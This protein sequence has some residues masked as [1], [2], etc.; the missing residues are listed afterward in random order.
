MT[1]KIDY[2][3]LYGALACALAS[4]R[5]ESGGYSE[6][7]KSRAIVIIEALKEDILKKIKCPSLD[8]I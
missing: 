4:L 5:N 1:E 6:E 7:E 8:S 3:P 2:E